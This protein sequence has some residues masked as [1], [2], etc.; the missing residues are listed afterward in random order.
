MIFYQ[1]STA[2]K[3]TTDFTDNPTLPY[4]NN[5]PFGMKP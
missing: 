1:T 2:L 3:Q 5:T 4:S